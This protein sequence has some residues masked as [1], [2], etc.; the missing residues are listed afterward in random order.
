MAF[1]TYRY[2]LT[3]NIPQNRQI[4]ETGLQVIP[5]LLKCKFS[6]SMLTFELAYQHKVILYLLSHCRH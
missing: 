6:S 2:D 5:H 4:R 1:L 3:R